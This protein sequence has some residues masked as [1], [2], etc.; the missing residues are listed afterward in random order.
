M[1]PGGRP[2]GGLGGARELPSDGAPGRGAELTTTWSRNP[3]NFDH[4]APMGRGRVRTLVLT[5]RAH[6]RSAAVG[7]G[8]SYVNWKVL[9][10]YVCAPGSSVDRGAIGSPLLPTH[11]EAPPAPRRIP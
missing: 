8:H 10:P 2:R 4:S 1:A 5:G 7:P 6:Q 3:A 9:T 11:A